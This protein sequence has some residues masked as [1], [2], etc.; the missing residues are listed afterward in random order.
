MR[1]FGCRVISMAINH[2]ENLLIAL[3]DTLQLVC[4]SF[5]GS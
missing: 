5:K 1:N 4:F 3:T 2:A